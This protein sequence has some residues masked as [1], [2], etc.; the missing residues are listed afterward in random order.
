VFRKYK[1]G[2]LI[3]SS[4][5]LSARI[6]HDGLAFHCPLGTDD[7]DKAA[8]KACEIYMAVREKGWHRAG[9][10]F[11][12]EI[13][14]GLVW[15]Q[16]PFCCTYTTLYSMTS[17]PPGITATR[18]ARRGKKSVAVIE[19]DASF[20]RA[21]CACVN[22]NAEFVCLQQFDNLK[23]AIE[24]LD[25]RDTDI[26]LLNRDL[27]EVL[28]SQAMGRIGFKMQGVPVWTY[29][30]YEDSDPIFVS[31]S[32]V[33]AGYILRRRNPNA[34]LE[35]IFGAS[36]YQR[37]TADD[38]FKKIRDYFQ[39][40]FSDTLELAPE[41]AA[42]GFSTREQEVVNYIRKGYID[43]EIASTAGISIWTVRKHLHK[44]YRKL[45][46]TTR[47]EAVIRLIGE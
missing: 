10:L 33:H 3:S 12:R 24:R 28:N 1:G 25:P 7:E 16:S 11:P 26:V 35:P 47:T 43:K 4:P 30:V 41:T 6:E 22:R 18:E 20:R 17:D 19:P 21:I 9:E 34:L 45:N 39:S 13:T 32:G 46:V 31:V 37:F 40:F 2:A 27:P 14:L 5:V 8:R 36:Q 15:A 44:I 29:G 42:Y 23:S 38:A